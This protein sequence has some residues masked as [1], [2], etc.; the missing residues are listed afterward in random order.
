MGTPAY[1]LRLA[2]T[3]EDWAMVRAL[4][5]AARRDAGG[6]E[7]RRDTAPGTV[8]FLLTCDGRAVG[9]TR[10]SHARGREP[11]PLPAVEAFAADL[12]PGFDRACIVEASLTRVDPA[13]ADPAL[14]V[15]RL[16]EAHLL[17]CAVR[18]ADW[19]VAA[20]PETRIGFYRRVL[21]MEILTGAQAMAEAATP[22]V[23]MG[24]RYRERAA[25]LYRRL[26]RVEFAAGAGQ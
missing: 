15:V 2:A 11:A 23:L 12:G 19:L 21:D 4:R 26:P 16:F 17:A 8:T 5:L 7:D 14:A 20:V 18:G 13:F 1:A 25:A 9:T 24:L 3:R 22:R 10:S 6:P